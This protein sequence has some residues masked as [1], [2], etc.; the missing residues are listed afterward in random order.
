MVIRWWGRVKEYWERQVESENVMVFICLA[1]EMTL[2][3]DVALL[4]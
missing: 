3:G 4:E 1:H 2:F